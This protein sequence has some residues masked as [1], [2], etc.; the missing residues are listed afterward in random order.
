MRRPQ[1]SLRFLF[2]AITLIGVVTSWVVYQLNWIR[3]R[4]RWREWLNA[5]AVGGSIGFQVEPKPPLPWSL[6]LFG[7]QPLDRCFVSPIDD[8]HPEDKVPT[9]DV[10][11][12]CV[13]R[14]TELFPECQIIDL[15]VDSGYGPWTKQ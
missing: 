10:F 9:F 3:E 11:R 14:A 15:T 4:H 13:E 5:H 12:R 1:F 6:A 2:V 8:E 7:E